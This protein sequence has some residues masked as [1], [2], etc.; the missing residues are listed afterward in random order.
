VLQLCAISSG[1]SG[2]I[3]AS[4][5]PGR[6]RAAMPA[7][8]MKGRHQGGFRNYSHERTTM[9]GIHWPSGE[10]KVPTSGLLTAERR[11]RKLRHQL[12][13]WMEAVEEAIADPPAKSALARILKH[14]MLTGCCRSLCSAM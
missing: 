6:L 4:A 11:W 8:H 3:S 13:L 7:R 9:Y 5:P 12:A 14:L 2:L 10:V 1:G